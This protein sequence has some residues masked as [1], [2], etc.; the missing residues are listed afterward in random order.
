MVDQCKTY[1]AHVEE[2]DG[3]LKDEN[4]EN[5][6]ETV[7]NEEIKENIELEDKE[8]ALQ[9]DEEEQISEQD[10]KLPGEEEEKKAEEVNYLEEEDP[11]K[12]LNEAKG[13]V[14]QIQEIMSAN[15]D[16][17]KEL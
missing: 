16:C 9:S 17:T 14:T 8:D 12:D 13:V 7:P 6:E 5:W 2:I 10:D 11:L 15:S 1:R 4:D 3:E